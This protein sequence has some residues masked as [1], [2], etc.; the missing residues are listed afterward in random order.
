MIIVADEGD[1]VTACMISYYKVRNL[2]M[3]TSLNLILA[4][5]MYQ[6]CSDI[7]IIQLGM[8]PGI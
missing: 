8:G 6:G 3:L 5:G 4:V 1:S 2:M 7:N